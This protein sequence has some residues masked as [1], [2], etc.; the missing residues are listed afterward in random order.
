MAGL[1][2]VSAE[3]VLAASL[4]LRR[5]RL[6][7]CALAPLVAWFAVPHLHLLMVT[8][9]PTSFYRSPTGFSSASIVEGPDC[10]TASQR[11]VEVAPRM[12]LHGL[13][14]L[15]KAPLVRLPGHGDPATATHAE[16]A[17]RRAGLEPR[18]G[19]PCRV[20]VLSGFDA[21]IVTAWAPST[22]AER[23]ACK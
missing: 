2:L 4:I 6:A 7:A 12:A 3:M 15:L 16:F 5:F 14:A 13:R 20:P 8:A 9:Y 22:A 23:A 21:G 17:E 11:N 1:S 19:N 18:V 10:H